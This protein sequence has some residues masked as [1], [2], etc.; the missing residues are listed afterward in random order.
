MLYKIKRQLITSAKAAEMAARMDDLYIPTKHV[1]DAASPL[2][3]AFEMPF[4]KIHHQLT[5]QVARIFG[6]DLRPTYNYGRIYQTG[7]TLP[8]HFDK[9]EC[10]YSITVNLSKTGEVWPFYVNPVGDSRQDFID[11]IETFEPNPKT[12]VQ[13]MI[14][15]G[16]AVVYQGFQVYHWRDP[17]PE[18]PHHQ[19]FFHWVDVNGPHANLAHNHRL[20]GSDARKKFKYAID[21]DPISL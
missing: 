15:P 21:H 10:E 11:N 2:S 6:V 12:T 3:P 16:D 17:L 20:V 19:M 5:P 4:C 1:P 8:F 7:D 13:C 18:G 14:E 9:D